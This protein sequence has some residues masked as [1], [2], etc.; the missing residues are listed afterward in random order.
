MFSSLLIPV[1]QL[2]NMLSNNQ[3]T[4]E[5]P[6]GDDGSSKDL[7]KR[8]I[9]VNEYISPITQTSFIQFSITNQFVYFSE[10]VPNN[11]SFEILVPPPNGC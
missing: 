7:G 11:H 2:G 3:L 9:N 10:L 6:H 4:E 5:L 1:Q 8:W